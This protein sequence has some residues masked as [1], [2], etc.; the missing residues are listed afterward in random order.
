M[1]L[2]NLNEWW[3]SNEKKLKLSFKKI[4]RWEL[5][6]FYTELQPIYTL[7]ITCKKPL[8]IESSICFTII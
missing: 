5:Q 4:E 7:Q 1:K 6:L 8:G 2:P 3:V